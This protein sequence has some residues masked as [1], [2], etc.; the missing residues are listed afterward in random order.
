M[1]SNINENNID[2]T[3]PVA[4][5]D[6]DSQGFRD[7]FT[8]IKNN[9][10]SAREEITDLQNTAVLKPPTGGGSSSKV[11]ND[12]TDTKLTSAEIRDFSET[13]EA[14]GTTSGNIALDHS[15]AHYFT[16]TTNGSVLLVFSN[17]P[18][19]GEKGRIQLEITISDVAHTLTLPSQVGKGIEGIQGLVENV[20]GDVITFAEAGDYLFEFTTA[21][22][23][24]TIHI[25]DKS[26]PKNSVTS[27]DIP[28]GGVIGLSTAASYFTTTGSET[29][30]LAAGTP[31]QVKTLVM[32]G[33]GGDMVVTVDNAGWKATGNGTITFNDIGDACTLQYINNKWYATGVFNTNFA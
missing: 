19:A 23:G 6:N 27:E 25:E 7:N 1:A 11:D 5:Q 17:L 28:D 14:I 32:A 21:D 8:T 29:A 31:G 24:T 30:T 18:P 10:T 15:T 16:A 33:D 22:G 26:R 3:Y 13:V 2:T 20:S 9:F 4:G 12:L